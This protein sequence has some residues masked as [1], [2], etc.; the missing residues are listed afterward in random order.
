[1]CDT[2]TVFDLLGPDEA[3]KILPDENALWVY[4][5]PYYRVLERIA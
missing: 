3:R 4:R 2:Q 1:M 5:R